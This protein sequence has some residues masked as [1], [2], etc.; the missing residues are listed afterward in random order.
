MIGILKNIIESGYKE[1]SLIINKEDYYYFRDNDEDADA[2][3][4][5]MEFIQV[6]FG[7][8]YRSNGSS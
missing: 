7:T 2:L 1:F 5:A 6:M 3:E 4:E 8:I